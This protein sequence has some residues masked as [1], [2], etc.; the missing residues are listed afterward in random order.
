MAHQSHSRRV[1]STLTALAVVGLAA[2]L[3]AC[4]SSADNT[5]NSGA[6]GAGSSKTSATVAS[7]RAALAKYSQETTSFP[8]V[9]PIDGLTKL[10]GK[11]VWYVPIGAS[12]PILSAYGTGL[13]SALNHLGIDVH[14]CDGKFLPTSIAACMSEAASQRADAV[15]TGYIHYKMVPTSF[16][17]LRAQ[18]IPVL[19]AGDIPDGSVKQSPKLAFYNTTP[20]VELM[21]KLNLDAVI[22]DSG[23]KAKIL[24]VGVTDS[25]QTKAGAS[26]AK[27]YVPKACPDCTFTQIEYNTASLTKVPSQVGAG[28]IANPGTTYVVCQLDPCAP[29]ALQG[30]RTAGKTKT[31]KLA[32]T[33]GNLDALQRVKSKDVQFVDVGS[34]P[35]HAGWLFADAMLRMLA[36][37]LPE[38]KLGLARVFTPGNVAGLKL[39]PAEYATNNWY[40]PSSYEQSFLKAWGAA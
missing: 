29:G 35:S 25:P 7:A 12:V 4:G 8:A 33:A 24:Y 1:T 3:S 5:S 10:K 9:T 31:V 36:G 28:L 11:T 14:V 6:S 32:S 27:S 17:K 26:Y 23:G 37:K 38:P 21:Q 20:T 34:S 13:K 30:I 18:D 15:V 19:V 16:Q 40:G 22:A 39:T 2:V